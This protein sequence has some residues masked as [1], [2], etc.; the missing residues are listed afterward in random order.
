[1]PVDS[2][3]WGDIPDD[4]HVLRGR[5]TRRLDQLLVIRHSDGPTNNPVSD[6]GNAFVA[7][8]RA[9][10]R[11]NDRRAAVKRSI[12]RLCGSSTTEEKTYSRAATSS[13]AGAGTRGRAR[14]VVS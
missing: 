13:K 7:V 8:A 4:I 5:T 14:G 1:M 2:I 9:I 6:H 11:M 3:D 10:C 12:D